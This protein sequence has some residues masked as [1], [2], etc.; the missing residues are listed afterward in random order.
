MKV[1]QIFFLQ[2]AV[3]YTLAFK[4]SKNDSVI[5]FNFPRLIWSAAAKKRAN[6][7]S[8]MKANKSARL[9][10]NSMF[11]V[12]VLLFKRNACLQR[13]LITDCF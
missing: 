6:I 9:N 2:N 12:I 3:S 8:K 13:H 11:N 1:T 5:F 4:M 10:P 7:W